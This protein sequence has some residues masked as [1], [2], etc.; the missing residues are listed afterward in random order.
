MPGKGK[1]GLM[2]AMPKGGDE[3]AEDDGPSLARRLLDAIKDDDEGALEQ[4]MSEYTGGGGES[5]EEY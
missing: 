5:D 3:P 2:I 1:L 4:C